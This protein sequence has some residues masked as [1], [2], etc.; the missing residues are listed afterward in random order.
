MNKSCTNSFSYSYSGNFLNNRTKI[1][2]LNNGDLFSSTGASNRVNLNFSPTF[3]YFN[4][5]PFFSY[6]EIWYDKY[7]LKSLNPADSLLVTN[8]NDAI[9][10]VRYF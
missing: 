2:S 10:A 9:K 8:E 6:T 3:K 4:I 5:R 1:S 7:I